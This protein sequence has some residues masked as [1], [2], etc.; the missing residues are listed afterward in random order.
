MLDGKGFDKSSPAGSYSLDMEAVHD[1]E[2]FM[3]MM[4]IAVEGVGEFLAY[5]EPRYDEAGEGE[6]EE[7]EI[8]VR[9]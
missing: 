3:E 4:R 6:F 8:Q 9:V 1:R 7:Y 5:P 2:A